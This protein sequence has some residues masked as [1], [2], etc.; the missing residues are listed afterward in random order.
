LSQELVDVFEGTNLAEMLVP[1]TKK[2]PIVL[3]DQEEN[4]LDVE[5]QNELNELDD[6][7]K[8]IEEEQ[9]RSEITLLE[10]QEQELQE[11]EITHQR[12]DSSNLEDLID[13]CRNFKLLWNVNAYSGNLFSKRQQRVH[14][15][16]KM[17]FFVEKIPIFAFE[18]KTILDKMIE[19][20]GYNEND[21]KNYQSLYKKIQE[22]KNLEQRAYLTRE[23]IAIAKSRITLIKS[24]EVPESESPVVDGAFSG[25]SEREM[26]E[27][28]KVDMF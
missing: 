13:L 2:F 5:I 21:F 20:D 22:E 12:I 4:E 7:Q 27:S 1:D 15:E 18:V 9:I 28:N 16:N 11:P 10:K 14:N 3:Y 25:S 17:D 23:L 8:N 24:Y 26:E 6:L 19:F